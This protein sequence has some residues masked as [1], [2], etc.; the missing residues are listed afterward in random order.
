M[1]FLTVSSKNLTMH[2][3]T[4][5]VTSPVVNLNLFTC[6]AAPYGTCEDGVTPID[7]SIAVTS[8][9]RVSP[10]TFV[11]KFNRVSHERDV[12]QVFADVALQ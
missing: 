6:R 10:D 7:L 2:D 8:V 9:T 1:P 11:I 4:A 5:G 12:A 3:L